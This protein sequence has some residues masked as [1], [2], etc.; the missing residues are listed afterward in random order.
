MKLIEKIPLKNNK[1]TWA[2]M[3]RYTIY[4]SLGTILFLLIYS[5]ILELIFNSN[6]SYL[7]AVSILKENFI[8]LNFKNHIFPHIFFYLLFEE[9]AFR[10]S[11]VI[12]LKHIAITLP[13]LLFLGTNSFIDESIYLYFY[14]LYALFIIIVYQKYAASKW[15]RNLN[16]VFSLLVLCGFH[17][18][19]FDLG[20]INSIEIFVQYIIPMMMVGSVLIY[21]RL[22]YDSYA[23]VLSYLLILLIVNLL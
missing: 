1:Y 4:I 15:M 5:F 16:I 17:L 21:L 7:N 2:N 13:L 8:R 19:K 22:K 10:K 6:T 3:L 11:L 23:S 12:S 20:D 14:G 18:S 9:L